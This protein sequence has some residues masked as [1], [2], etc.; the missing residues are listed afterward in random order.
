MVSFIQPISHFKP[1]P[2]PSFLAG[3]VT[4]DI[5]ELSSAIMNADVRWRSTVLRWRKNSKLS[6]LKSVPYLLGRHFS[7]AKLL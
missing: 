3:A 2:S 4:P 7:L 5:M 6:R 1:K